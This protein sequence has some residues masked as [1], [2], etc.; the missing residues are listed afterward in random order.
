MAK[1]SALYNP[2]SFP[3]NALKR[4]NTVL[5]QMEKYG[6]ISEQLC[7]SVKKTTVE[8]DFNKVDYNTG[9]ATYFRQVI[10]NELLNLLEEKNEDGTY[11]YS[12]SKGKK[13]DLFS[14]GLK[15][16]T[17]IDY[18]MQ[19]YAEWAVE[20]YLGQTLQQHFY[21][22][23]KSRRNWPF[24]NSIDQSVIDDL[25]WTAIKQ[26]HRYQ[27][28]TENGKKRMP[29]KKVMEAFN[30][31][32][33]MKVFTWKGEKDT[34]MTP[35][36]SI[37][38]YKSFLH[39]GLLS[40]D[41]KTGLVKAW[42][43]GINSKYFSLDHVKQTKRQVGSIFKPIL[44]AAA[45]E[46]NIMH[47]CEEIANIPYTLTRKE[48]KATKDWTPDYGPK[49]DGMV[50]Y[51][52]GLANSMNNIAVKV[53]QQIEDPQNV[54][55]MAKRLGIESHLEPVASI[56]LG[57]SD[58]SLYEMVG[59]LST[60]ANQGFYRKPTCLLRLEDRRGNVIGTFIPEGAEKVNPDVAYTVIQMMKSVVDGEYN[61]SEKKKRGTGMS[62]RSI[63]KIEAPVAGK[64]GTTQ[65]STDG[66]FIAMTPDLVTGV[67]VGAD[68]RA[69]RFRSGYFGQGAVMALPIC[70]LYMRKCYLNST[71]KIT[72]EDFAPPEDYKLETNCKAYKKEKK[73]DETFDNEDFNN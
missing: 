38:Y 68:D 67:W 70:G 25:M 30:K 13:Y 57:V 2:R 69:V 22:D 62:L 20:H 43:G 23:L 60:F 49:F 41:P 18:K 64:T 27:I 73:D 42:V 40:V 4:R 54:I 24:S 56:G 12:N 31:P 8:L 7:D 36:D 14:D 66:W 6:F 53:M 33:K 65:K 19:R 35:I 16:Y 51:K 21:N 55:D 47:P 1:S 32:A 34:I 37:K 11:R 50:T 48:L 15:I 52:Y 61:E 10:R 29:R 44:Y 58:I 45:L 39:A 72:E 5:N 3:T 59:A 71:I 26:S 9:L 46:E 17:S 63:Y 28:M